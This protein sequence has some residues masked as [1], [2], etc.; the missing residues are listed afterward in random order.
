MRFA[1]AQRAS[2]YGVHQGCAPPERQ[3]L[4]DI[5]RATAQLDL[6]AELV[7]TVLCERAAFGKAS[8]PQSSRGRRCHRDFLRRAA[9]SRPLIST[10]SMIFLSL[11]AL[12]ER[13]RADHGL[14]VLSFTHSDV[15]A[16]FADRCFVL[17]AGSLR[18]A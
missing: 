8:P 2:I 16:G 15:M 18:E 10:N 7:F 5:Q 3:R 4:R 9:S 17:E 11:G 1:C 13:L 12:L 14:T 6:K